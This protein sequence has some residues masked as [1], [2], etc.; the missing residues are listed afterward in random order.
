[1]KNRKSV[2]LKSFVLSG[3]TI[4][5]MGSIAQAQTSFR[6]LNKQ[7]QIAYP[8]D[9]SIMR[10][11]EAKADSIISGKN[12]LNPE[13]AMQQLKANYN[14]K[15]KIKTVKPNTKVL[16]T[17]EIA[18][19]LKQSAVIF[20]DA[21]LCGKCDNTHISPASGYVIDESGII[22]TNH[23]VVEAYT[24]PQENGQ[25]K[26]SLQIM[27]GDREVY[28]VTEVLST[29][30]QLDIAI[31]KVDVGNRK[32]IPLPIGP[33]VDLGTE[34][35]VLSNPNM[36]FNFFSKGVVSRKYSRFPFQGSKESFPEMDITADYAAGSS[37]APIVDHMGN[38]VSTVSTTRSIYYNNQKKTDLQMVVKG[39]RPVIGLK[40]LL[41]Y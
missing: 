21:Y 19:R 14:K 30:P 20:A 9:E 18:K 37:G 25:A 3:L 22:V 13:V 29:N 39:T 32:L 15:V 4:F 24:K 28:A 35:F 16:S 26:L 41:I 27:T 12:F 5:A 31:V 8:T 33:D 6:A 38:L 2:L 10:R 40:E 36:M 11:F 17:E 7:E 23:H 34:V 1:M